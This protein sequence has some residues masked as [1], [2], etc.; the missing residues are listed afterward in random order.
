MSILRYRSTSTPLV[1]VRIAELI[2]A[3]ALAP[4]FLLRGSFTESAPLVVVLG[5]LWCQG[6]SGVGELQCGAVAM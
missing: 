5:E 1:N 4:N 3:E 2:D 6:R